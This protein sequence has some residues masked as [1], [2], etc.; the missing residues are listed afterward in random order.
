ME[1]WVGQVWHKLITRS[2]PAEYPDAEIL[3]QHVQRPVALLFRALGGEGGMRVEAATESLHGARRNLLSRIAGN[4]QHVE[5]AWRDNETLYLPKRIA[6]FNNAVLNRELYLWLAALAA[7]SPACPD[8]KETNSLV[9]WVSS[10]EDNTMFLLQQYPGLARRYEKL[11]AAHLT[12]RPDPADLPVLEAQQEMAI[13]Q[14]LSGTSGTRLSIDVSVKHRPAPVPLWLHP[15][16]PVSAP[17][18]LPRSEE[19]DEDEDD[20]QENSSEEIESE[21]RNRGER[22]DEPE[23]KGGLLA[24]RLESLFTRTE[25]VAVDRTE[26]E[27][28]DDAKSSIEDLDV[29][30]MSRTRNKIGAKLRFDLDLP[31]EEHDD[32]RLGEGIPLPEWDYRCAQLQA[33]H[34]RL[35]PMQA[36]DT[37]DTELPPHLRSKARRLRSVFEALKPRRI[38]HPG[39]VDGSEI[40]TNALIRQ[41]TD[42]L[43]GQ[44]STEANLYRNF[45]NTERDL[46]CLVLAD[47]SLSTDAHVDNEQRVIDVIR[48]S[49]HLFSE[50]LMGTGDRFALYGFSSR[51]RSHVRYHTLKTFDENHSGTVRG[52]INAIK[53]GYYTRMGAAIRYSTQL[54]AKEASSQKLLLILTDGKPNDLDKYE[55][56]YGVEDTRVAVREATREGIQPFC[57]TID[58][59]AGDYLPYLFGSSSF[60]LMRNARELP[61]KLPA[62]YARLTR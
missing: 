25:Y 37:S 29:L 19:T 58:K 22:V 53:P 40:D 9:Q 45:R 21:K 33:N 62:L 31:S 27:N 2:A 60:V 39:Q 32:V 26:D 1:E 49:L 52:R 56:R 44:R 57:V 59:K 16:P 20:E 12:Q 34:C 15:E 4:N 8:A 41:A 3:L 54:L 46:S 30:S 47:L 18:L 6:Y 55:G 51:H 5:L 10:N 61:S 14:A 28:A 11:L 50:A 24:F 7:I 13:R 43:R 42:R 23:G 36:R 35:Q 17:V 38:W 48:D